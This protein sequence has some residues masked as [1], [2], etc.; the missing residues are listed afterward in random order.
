MMNAG[1]SPAGREF[2]IRYS[3]LHF[4]G[5]DKP[6]DS[7]ARIAETKRLARE[8]GREIQVWEPETGWRMKKIR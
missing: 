2:A 7:T 8:S 4:D 5:V 6:E 1:S 3:D